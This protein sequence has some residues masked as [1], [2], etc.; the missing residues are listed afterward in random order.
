M[1]KTTILSLSGLQETPI[2]RGNRL[3]Q[4]VV[5][6]GCLL[7]AFVTPARP[8]G[9]ATEWTWMGGSNA[10]QKPGVYGTLGTP[11][12]GNIP[13]SRFSASSWSDSSGNFWLFGGVGYDGNGDYG[14]LN[15][16]WEFNPSTNEWAWMGGSNMI[17]FGAIED[18][19][20]GTLGTPAAGN[21]PGCRWSAS[22]W[23]DSSGNFWLFGGGSQPH[24]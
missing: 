13:G 6:C 5:L 20:Y 8:Q 10:G 22:S 12:A 15:D 1:K 4:V 17:C 9:A 14:L 24:I 18:G 19:V 16:L 21:I 23:T 2:C 7:F 11:A 3:S